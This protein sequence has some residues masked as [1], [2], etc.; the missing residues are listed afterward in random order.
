MTVGF[1][2][3]AQSEFDEASARMRKTQRF[4]YG[5]VYVPETD[6]IVIVAGMHGSR[7]P[8]YWKNRLKD[9]EP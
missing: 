2:A 5:V 7:R 1:A 6:R 8:G 3:A 4:P 9:L